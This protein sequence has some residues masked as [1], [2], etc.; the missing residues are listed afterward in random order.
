MNGTELDIRDRLR[1]QFVTSNLV[2]D[3]APVQYAK[4]NGNLVIENL[5]VFRSG[6]FRDSMGTQHTWEPLHMDQMVTHFDI[7]KSREILTAVPVRDGHPSFLVRGMPGAGA[8]VGWHTGVSAET[9]TSKVDGQDYHYL[10]ANFEFTEP[11]A[12][13]KFKR[14]TFRNWSSEIGE[15]TTNSEATFWPV[16]MGFAFVDLPAVEGLHLDSHNADHSK[17]TVCF[18]K[19][20]KMPE[21][22]PVPTPP[23]PPAVPVPMPAVQFNFGGQILNDPNAIQ[24]EIN[25]LFSKN[26]DLQTKVDGFVQADAERVEAA[27]KAFTKKLVEDN[28]ILAPQ[29]EATEQF[30]LSL[31]PEQFAAWS[32]QW[33]TAPTNPLLGKHGAPD[34]PTPTPAGTGE[35]QKTTRIDVLEDMILQHMSSGVP[36]IKELGSYKEL[37]T[38]APQSTVLARVK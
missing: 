37:A 33:E 23:A 11:E 30:A 21:T 31:T 10:F 2:K 7:L 35:E 15:Y 22:P 13:E 27:R 8:V 14:G 25:A 36:N 24:Q 26:A 1:L 34:T 16:Y 5:P 12:A 38:L 3:V 4:D 19:G 20:L 6:T 9:R 28:K 18:E 17:F 29:L 32:S